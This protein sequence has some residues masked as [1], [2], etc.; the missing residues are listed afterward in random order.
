MTHVCFRFIP[1]HEGK[2]YEVEH[3]PRIGEIINFDENLTDFIVLNIIY[4]VSKQLIHQDYYSPYS[5]EIWV[6]EK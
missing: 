5:V 1:S 2:I 4:K 6:T 3:I